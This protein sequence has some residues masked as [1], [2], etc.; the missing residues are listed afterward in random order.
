MPVVMA[1]PVLRSSDVRAVDEGINTASLASP[2]WHL[3]ARTSIAVRGSRS[4][5]WPSS[6]AQPPS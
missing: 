5:R 6:G 2:S 4:L 3:I 1:I